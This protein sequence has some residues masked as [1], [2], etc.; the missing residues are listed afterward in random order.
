[1]TW[2]TVIQ[3]I[4]VTNDNGYAPLVVNT[5]RSFPHSW[6][7]NGFVTRL[8]LVPPVEQERLTL[9]EHLSSLP[10]FSGVRV[11]R[12]LV[13]YICFVDRCLSFCLFLLVIVL[14]VLLRSTESDY[15]FGIFTLFLTSFVHRSVTETWHK[16]SLHT[17]RSHKCS[18][19]TV[20]RPKHYSSWY[21]WGIANNSIKQQSN[22]QVSDCCL[23][24]TWAL[25]PLYNGENKLH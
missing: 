13:L 12:S 3:N 24:P 25:L 8:T 16:C 15:T 2:L 22:D 14:S 9:P 7:I 18:L 11:T 1:M 17:V 21:R 19:H 20:R 23:A 5:F 4:C 10:V 6:L